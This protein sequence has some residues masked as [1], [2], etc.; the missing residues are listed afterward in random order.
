MGDK[1]LNE[2]FAKELE[3]EDIT[4]HT[5]LGRRF[6]TALF[7]YIVDESVSCLDQAKL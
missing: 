5:T 7:K 4:R 3:E 1:L 2:S 6:A